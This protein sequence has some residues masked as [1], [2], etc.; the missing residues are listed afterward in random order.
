MESQNDIDGKQEQTH[1]T[2]GRSSASE[3]LD[4]QEK[5]P[6]L[7]FGL[8]NEIHI[9][10]QLTATAFNRSQPKDGLH[11]SHFGILNHLLRQEGPRSP[12]QIASAFQVTRATMTNSLARLESR[13]YIKV[14]ANPGD[15]RGKLVYLTPAGRK[16]RDACIARVLPVIKSWLAELDVDDLLNIMPTLTEFRMTV[17][18]NRLPDG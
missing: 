8:I 5:L 6:A 1:D 3:H 14:C 12:A 15:K 9:L 11:V 10:H 18:N 16:E 4:G 13:G 2:A 17:D 7:V